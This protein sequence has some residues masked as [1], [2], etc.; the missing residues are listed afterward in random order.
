M[1]L[2]DQHKNMAIYAIRKSA[3]LRD[4]VIGA[5]M[6]MLQSGALTPGERVTEDGLVRQLSV[7]RTPIREALSQLAH[8]GALHVRPGGGFVVPLPTVGELHETIVVRLLLEPPALRMAATEFGPKQLS[9]IDRAIEGEMASVSERNPLRFAQANEA[10]RVA[11]F[12]AISNKTLRAAIAQFNSHLHFIRSSTLEDLELRQNIV[13]RQ[14]R[15]REAIA[16]HDGDVAESL[17][18]SYLRLTEDTLITALKAFISQPAGSIQSTVAADEPKAARG[19]GRP[20][21]AAS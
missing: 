7:S 11:I 6:D 8:R 21:K 15:I 2:R 20:R 9:A 12:G 3:T 16:S 19:R 5:V 17:W 1:R 4:Q 10:F 13:D 14:S 18:K